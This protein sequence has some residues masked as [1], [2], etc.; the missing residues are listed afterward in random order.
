MST[1]RTRVAPLVGPAA[2]LPAVV[3]CGSELVAPGHIRHSTRGLLL[4]PEGQAAQCLA[5][6]FAGTPCSARPTADWLTEA[7]RKLGSNVVANG[8]TGLTLQ[9]LGVLRRPEVRELAERLLTEGDPA[10]EFFI[11]RRWS[12]AIETRAPGRGAVT[13]ETLGDGEMVGWSWLIPPYRSA[14]DARAI[15]TAHVI[16]LDG[17]CLRGKCEQ[18]PALGY[19]LMKVVA[20][21]F[22]HRLTETR[23][24]L[25]DLYAGIPGA[26]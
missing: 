15:D 20:A 4:V 16:V 25:L 11:V 23:I 1:K 26:A 22:V 3:Y 14:F 12:V 5:E 8:I 7:W 10:D 9:P 21:T 17:A 24:R 18:D 6:L 19:D 2:V 13:I